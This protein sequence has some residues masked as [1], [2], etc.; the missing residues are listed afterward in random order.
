[1]LV[2]EWAQCG[3]WSTAR[4]RAGARRAFRRGGMRPGIGESGGG[5]DPGMRSRSGDPGRYAKAPRMRAPSQT[6]VARQGP[7]MQHDAASRMAAATSRDWRKRWS[8]QSPERPG[9][10]AG[11]EHPVY[12]IVASQRPERRNPRG[13]QTR[14]C[15][16][17]VS[18]LVKGPSYLVDDHPAIS[19]QHAT[20]ARR[21]AN[22]MG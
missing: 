14:S 9:R 17:P 10:H 21:T 12:Q 5:A 11:Y 22:Q 15:T 20:Y 4:R 1:M 2:D 8:A 18:L 6:R 13:R 19:V 7:C 3:E 16:Q